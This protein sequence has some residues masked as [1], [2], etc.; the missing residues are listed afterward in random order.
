[1]GKTKEWEQALAGFAKPINFIPGFEL[2]KLVAW[3]GRI[4]Q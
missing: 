2:S 4:Q 3:E 1:V